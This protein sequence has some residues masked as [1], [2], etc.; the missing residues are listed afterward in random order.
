MFNGKEYFYTKLLQ[1][2]NSS[3][4]LKLILL[5]MF[6][7]TTSIDNNTYSAPSKLCKGR[8]EAL[9]PIE[10]DERTFNDNAAVSAPNVP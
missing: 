10:P 1:P 8:N 9:H 6:M 7:R 2:A 3:R 4:G 5:I